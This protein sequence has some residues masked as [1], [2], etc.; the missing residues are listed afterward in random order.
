[1]RRESHRLCTRPCVLEACNIHHLSVPVSVFL[2]H[3]RHQKRSLQIFNGVAVRRKQWCEVCVQATVA[4]PDLP[5][6]VSEA[7]LRLFG[8]LMSGGNVEMLLE[9]ANNPKKARADN[10]K[11]RA[12]FYAHIKTAREQHK[13]GTQL[14]RGGRRNSQVADKAFAEALKA[15]NKASTFVAGAVGLEKE[16]SLAKQMAGEVRDAKSV[17]AAE[18]AVR[19]AHHAMAGGH[20]AAA[21]G[22]HDVAEQMYEKAAVAADKVVKFSRRSSITHIQNDAARIHGS[23]LEGTGAVRDQ[24]QAEKE[25]EA[26]VEAAAEAAEREANRLAILSFSDP[27]AI[28]ASLS[29]IAGQS[30]GG[31]N[32]AGSGAGGGGDE[33]AGSNNGASGGN[34]GEDGG[35]RDGGSDDGGGSGGGS[36][37]D[38]GGIDDEAAAGSPSA[39]QR[40]PVPPSSASSG[41]RSGRSP[42]ETGGG[43][44]SSSSSSSKQGR[45]QGSSRGRS[46]IDKDR[47]AERESDQFTELL[48]GATENPIKPPRRR[49]RSSL[50]IASLGLPERTLRALN[51]DNDPPSSPS[52]SL[53][54]SSSSSS[55]SSTLSP[56]VAVGGHGS[57]GSGGGVSGGMPHA[58]M[59][60]SSRR[61]GSSPR[62][63]LVA[64]RKLG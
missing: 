52:S 53:S 59:T 64:G 60:N 17:N 51:K 45:S 2:S 4:H 42:R 47:A 31:D 23:A 12:S 41:R 3:A 33:S 55:S 36:G 6:P 7:R 21:K 14:V 61:N 48:A 63:P 46:Q 1:M 29:A 35:G 20:A 19:V 10:K 34:D 50:I 49:R 22:Q 32:S 58:P 38:R 40:E 16:A 9:M 15:V 24:R 57:E 8:F 56:A 5:L 27:T 25:E 37:G 26:A 13:R 18:E 11:R 43:S 39:Q 62:S 30:S 28:E 54:S 44:S